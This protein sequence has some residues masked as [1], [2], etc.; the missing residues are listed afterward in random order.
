M[1]KTTYQVRCAN[2]KSVIEQ[3]QARPEGQSAKQWL[4]D[5]NVYE[6]KY[7]YWLRKLRKEAYDEMQSSLQTAVLPS[8]DSTRTVP[9]V[10]Y[11][12]FSAKGDMVPKAD[13][14]LPMR[15]K[16]VRSAAAP[17]AAVLVVANPAVG[18]RAIAPAA[19]PGAAVLIAGQQRKDVS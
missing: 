7:Y 19:V 17:R 8:G 18:Q 9:A 5:N 15:R 11:A 2:W 14:A 6:K 16:P 4:A 1:D 10:S 3:C 13:T 12:A